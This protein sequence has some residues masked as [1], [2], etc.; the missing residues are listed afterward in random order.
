MGEFGG[1][2]PTGNLLLV[3]LP[4]LDFCVEVENVERAIDGLVPDD[5]GCRNGGEKGGSRPP[6]FLS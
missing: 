4:P 1:L 3:F 6:N 2:G 5:N